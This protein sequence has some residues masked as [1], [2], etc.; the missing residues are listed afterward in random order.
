MSALIWGVTMML[1]RHIDD[2]PL[3]SECCYASNRASLEEKIYAAWCRQKKAILPPW[4]S[5]TLTEKEPWIA[6]A[7]EAC[8][9]ILGK[10]TY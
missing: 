8:L 1:D 2:T 9:V 5:L 7:S 4:K 6:A 10:E 3:L